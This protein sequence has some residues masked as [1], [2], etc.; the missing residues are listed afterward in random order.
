MIIIETEH[1]MLAPGALR[2]GAALHVIGQVDRG[3]AHPN[4][5]GA[6]QSC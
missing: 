6:D 3:R 5:N 2:S 4:G 1:V